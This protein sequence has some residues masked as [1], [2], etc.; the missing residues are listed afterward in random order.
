MNADDVV[1]DLGVGDLRLDILM[2]ERA[3]KVYAVEVNPILVGRVLQV[4]GYDLPRNL[5]I[6]C[7]NLFDIEIPKDITLVLILMRHCTRHEEIFRRFKKFKIISNFNGEL[8]ITDK[9]I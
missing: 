2:T 8:R 4:I 9:S 7:A 6:I 3:K 5:I 1:L